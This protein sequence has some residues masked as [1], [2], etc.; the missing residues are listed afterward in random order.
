MDTITA[1]WFLW[2]LFIAFA[3]K[4]RWSFFYPAQ[5]IV[6]YGD[7]SEIIGQDKVMVVVN[8]ITSLLSIIVV[9]ALGGCLIFLNDILMYLYK[10]KVA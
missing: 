3:L 1:R 9:F 6:K 5:H 2:I 4:A 7:N 10:L 8:V